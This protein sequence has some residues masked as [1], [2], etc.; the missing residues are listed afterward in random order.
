MRK[1]INNDFSNDHFIADNKN[2][3]KLLSGSGTRFCPLKTEIV[4][5]PL[6]ILKLGLKETK[7]KINIQCD[8]GRFICF[9]W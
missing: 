2:V 4:R 8:I 9:N 1:N 7:S 5:F 6:D 3:V